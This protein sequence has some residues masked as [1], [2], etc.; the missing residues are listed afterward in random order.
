MKISSDSF[1]IYRH[2]C[3]I[4][5]SFLVTTVGDEVNFKF[6]VSTVLGSNEMSWSSI[7]L[8]LELQIF[9]YSLD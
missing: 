3:F 6:Q 4:Q 5:A 8:L 9:S 7:K 1:P 2:Q